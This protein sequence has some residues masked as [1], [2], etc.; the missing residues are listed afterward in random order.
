MQEFHTWIWEHLSRFEPLCQHYRNPPFDALVLPH[1]TFL[2]PHPH[3]SSCSDAALDYWLKFIPDS[4]TKL[5][6]EVVEY[7]RTYWDLCRKWNHKVLARERKRDLVSSVRWSENGPYWTS[8][9]SKS[10]TMDL[11]SGVGMRE[12]LSSKVLASENRFK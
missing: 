11:R 2:A 10:C 3:P 1:G 7:L 6:Y 8:I 9:T 5:R 12:R 4:E